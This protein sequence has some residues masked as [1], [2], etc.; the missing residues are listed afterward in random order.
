MMYSKVFYCLPFAL[1][2][3]SW[4]PTAVLG[5]P[6]DIQSRDALT[7]G[8]LVTGG[9]AT[10]FL[11]GGAAG[12]CGKVHQDTDLVAAIDK[13]SFSNALCGK[14]VTITNVAN[15][16]SVTATIADECPGCS[17]AQSIDLSKGAFDKIADESTGVVD[18]QW[19]LS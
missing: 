6:V 5:A 1:A 16:K 3:S 14:S 9:K 18:I 4:V 19:T 2:I 8:K 11:Q 17:N 10:F 7:P 15:K 13:G 12:A